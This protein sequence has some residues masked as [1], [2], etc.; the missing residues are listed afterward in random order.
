MGLDTLSWAR[1]GARVTGVDFSSKAV[2]AA[3]SLAAE[4]GI[5]ARFICADVYEAPDVLDE[6][7]DI[8]YTSHG[9]LGWLP[10]LRGWAQ[11]V[12]RFASP[13]GIFYLNEFHPFA[14]VFDDSDQAT[15]LR[16]AYPYFHSPEPLK[17]PVRGSYADPEAVV[18][19][20]VEYSWV[21][22]LGDVITSLVE[23][24]LEIRY[25]H[26]F[27]FS[28]FRILP[29]MTRRDDGTWELPGGSLPAEYSVMAAK[30]GERENRQSRPRGAPLDSRSS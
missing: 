12:A 13:G 29:L 24:G 8:V 16:V 22:S 18:R 30:P 4:T 25:L 15:E 27:P 2:A 3:S 23:A 6:T 17:L 28:S 1:R 10:D 19:T 26:E 11:V 9:V 20:P 7:F 5:E 21:H 14:F